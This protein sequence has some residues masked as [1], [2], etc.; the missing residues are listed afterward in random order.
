MLLGVVGARGEGHTHT[1]LAKTHHAFF[2]F[3]SLAS[4][5]IS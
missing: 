4:V 1:S 5:R 3:D 2:V